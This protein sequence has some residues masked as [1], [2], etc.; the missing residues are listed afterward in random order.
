MSVQLRRLLPTALLAASLLAS[1]CAADH[2]ITPNPAGTHANSTASDPTP[3]AELPKGIAKAETQQPV[4]G[5]S[6]TVTLQHLERL[7]T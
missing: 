4:D 1:G 2:D 7:P 6:W 3:A 5:G